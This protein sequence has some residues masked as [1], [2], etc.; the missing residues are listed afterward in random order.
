MTTLELNTTVDMALF[1]EFFTAH[2]KQLQKRKPRKY[3]I[4]ER[5]FII[6]VYFGFAAAISFYGNTFA[7]PSFIIML[8]F[9]VFVYFEVLHRAMRIA[10]TITLNEDGLALGKHHYLFS[11]EGINA[12]GSEYNMHINWSQV[13]DVYETKNAYVIQLDQLFGFVIRK[14]DIKDFSILEQIVQSNIN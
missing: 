6:F 12:S 11:D 5:V 2:E 10:D 7:W 8:L 14:S 3:T 9:F 1:K 13:S 4:K